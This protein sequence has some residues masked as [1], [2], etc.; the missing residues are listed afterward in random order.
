[1]TDG[2]LG[3][4]K[5]AFPMAIGEDLGLVYIIARSRSSRKSLKKLTAR[6]LD[7]CEWVL[8]IGVQWYGVMLGWELSAMAH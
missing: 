5:G 2:R 3:A 1:M 4:S 7:A 6:V 8:R